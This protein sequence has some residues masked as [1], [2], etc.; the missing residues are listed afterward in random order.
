[1]R[2]SAFI[3]GCAS[4]LM[5]GGDAFAQ[6]ITPDDLPNRERVQIEDRLGDNFQA[7]QTTIADQSDVAITIYNNNLALVKDR[8]R[9]N[10]IPGEMTLRFM[11][12]A[13]MIKPETVSMR[14][15]TSPGALRILEQ[16]YEFDLINYQ[17]LMEKYVGKNVRLVNF[18]D[19]VGFESVD[20]KLISM[21]GGPV[22]EVDG[23][24][25]LN[26]P[27]SV[28]LP[29]IP[30]NLIAKPSLIW[31]LDNRGTDQ[32][33]EVTYL[34]QGVSWR[35]DYV[36]TYDD[37]SGVMD[38]DS[39]I[40]LTNS[41]GAAYEN[42]KLKLVAGDVN[43]LQQMYRGG[44]MAMESRAVMA[45][46]PMPKQESFAEYH[47]YT[48]QRP[49]TIKENQSKQVNLFSSQGIK[50][51]RVYEYRGQAHYYSQQIPQFAPDK[52]AS[53]LVFE[54]EEENQ[55]GMPLPAGI[56]RVYQRDSE[57]ALQFSGED[58]VDHTPKDEEVRLKLGNAFD[59]VGERVQT[60]FR[61]ISNR[62]IESSYEVTL[63]NH[64]EDDIVVDVVEPF[65]SDWEILQSNIEHVKKDARTAVFSVPVEAD[66]E[67]VLRYRV[68]VTS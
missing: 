61:R 66:G 38:L 58:R 13:Q 22:Y 20:A 59:V 15:I 44:A 52:V 25:F 62:V 48:V 53:Y 24:I 54:N 47:L 67:V 39:W 2:I 43:Q 28:A 45:D 16:N 42:A 41:S 6:D 56:M 26:H 60:D 33:I 64:K 36:V 31:L 10:L 17:K 63:R 8:R 21:N 12:V 34:T 3:L 55:L 35:A 37:K 32:E 19:Q 30:E 65:Y 50:V 40:T 1:M 14:S 68:R 51:D 5:A 23:Q 4:A 7:T 57:G 9:L 18:S 29:E 49:T 27:G 46:A 11:D